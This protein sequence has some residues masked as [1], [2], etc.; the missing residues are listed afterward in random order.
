MNERD[1]ETIAGILEVL[2]YR[3]A[4][5]KDDVD[6]VILNTCSVRQTTENRIFGKLGELK[7]FKRLNPDAVLAVSGC[8][9]QQ[10]GILDKMNRLAPHVDLVLGT[11]NLH[12][13]QELLARVNSGEKVREVWEHE[14]EI[15]E[16]LP[17]VR[18]SGIR[19][20]VNIMYGCDNFCSYCIVP[21][22]RGRERSRDPEEIVREVDGLIQRGFKEIMLLG[23]NV[24]SYGKGLCAGIGFAGLLR[25]LDGLEGEF[26]IR[27]MT[28]HPK[29][30]SLDIVDAV[31]GSR[32]IC[33]HFHLPVQAG[34]NRV[35]KRM[36]RHYNREAY[37]DLISQVRER[38]PGASVTTDIIVGFPG[39]DEADFADT[40]DLIEKM[41]FDAAYT[42]VYSPRAGTPAA[43]LEDAVP[44][45]DKKE[46]LARLMNAQNR[47]SLELNRELEGKT[48]EVLVEGGSRTNP[49][50]LSGRT[51]TNKIV[52]FEGPPELA[53]RLVD[54]IITEARTW[55]LFGSLPPK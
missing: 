33:E 10:P 32:H 52:L 23:Q 24:N 28:S 4:D 38:V 22:V 42:F 31:A 12:R 54:V 8:M 37:M 43:R 55:T 44:P 11:H 34:S 14:G 20:Y 3:P 2:G 50:T 53:G 36:N 47:I 51:R 21:Y 1:S 48:L 35:L 25:E 7:Q 27:Y 17:A 16:E 40:M 5:N 9:A 41:R 15:V 39:E 6:L 49:K 18:G 19:A 30:F 13:L 29:D 26:R 45:K 46:N